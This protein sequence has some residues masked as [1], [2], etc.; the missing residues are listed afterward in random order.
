MRITTNW[1]PPY[2]RVPLFGALLT[3]GALILAGLAWSWRSE[4]EPGS[5]RL[6]DA[7]TI[8]REASRAQTRSLSVPP[9]PAS[10]NGYPLWVEVDKAEVANP[11]PFA[12]E[13]STEGRLLVRISEMA[14]AGSWR[15]GDRLAL[16]VPQVGETYRP[17][18]EAI[19]DGPG[20]RAFLGRTDGPEGRRRCVLTVGPTSLFAYIDTPIGP[21]ELLADHAYGW[22]LPSS[23]LGALHVD[24]PAANGS[25]GTVPDPAATAYAGQAD[26]RD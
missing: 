15:I 3:C 6:V 13:W 14:A 2:G 24:Q 12:V 17:V 23:S 8:E 26:E 11:P 18:I 7:T 1:T 16:P 19:D 10:A 20:A 4:E 5:E 9:A 22:L 21:Y 25:R